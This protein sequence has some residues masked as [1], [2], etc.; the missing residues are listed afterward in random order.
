MRVASCIVA[1]A[2]GCNGGGYAWD[3]TSAPNPTTDPAPV[4]AASGSAPEVV[5]AEDPSP[6]GGLFTRCRQGLAAET[7][8]VRDV[9]RLASVCGPPTGMEPE[10]QGIV[11]GALTPEQPVRFDLAMARGRCYRVIAV[12]DPNVTELEVRVLSQRGTVLASD[13]EQGRSAVVQPDRPFC[14]DAEEPATIEVASR[15]GSGAF[16]LEVLSMAAPRGH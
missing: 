1:C 2:I 8:P 12:S 11:E 3:S 10:G 4:P 9:A 15:Q 7:D 6:H 14:T 13:H 16:A 5:L